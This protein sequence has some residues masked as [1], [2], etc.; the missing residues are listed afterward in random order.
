MQSR[1]HIK[2]SS[3][4]AIS[5][6]P[7]YHNHK[8]KTTQ[9]HIVIIYQIATS[10]SIVSFFMIY[11]IA[12]KIFET[13]INISITAQPKQPKVKFA[14][15]IQSCV[16]FIFPFI[17]SIFS[18]INSRLSFILSNCFRM[19]SSCFS[20][21]TIF[22]KIKATI[23]QNQTAKTT[24]KIIAINQYK[25]WISSA[26]LVFSCAFATSSCFSAVNLAQWFCNLFIVINAFI[27]LYV[28]RQNFL[29]I[30]MKLYILS[31]VI[32]QVIHSC[33]TH[34][35]FKRSPISF[36]LIFICGFDYIYKSQDKSSFHNVN[37]SVPYRWQTQFL[38]IFETLSFV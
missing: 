8:K 33:L 7:L 13:I 24:T 32:S 34:G 37:L 21:Y 17:W 12:I 30:S 25:T 31:F 1:T 28:G 5:Y 20:I 11:F 22:D 23:V 19:I 29:N 10:K 26:F 6:P 15:S 4:F 35:I 18:W 27:Y 16:L 3:V 2:A 38:N 36:F 9:E 14:F